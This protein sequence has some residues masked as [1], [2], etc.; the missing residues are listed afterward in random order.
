MT[1]DF[2]QRQ[3]QRPQFGH[4]PSETAIKVDHNTIRARMRV[5]SRGLL[6]TGMLSVVIAIAGLAGGIIY[7]A[8]NR[9]SI[10]RYWVVQLFGEE[11]ADINPRSTSARV[12]ELKEKR[13]AQ[14]QTAFALVL[15]AISIGCLIVA[16]VYMMYVSGGILM[17]QLKNYR[18]CR[19]V[20]LMAIVPVISPLIVVGIPFG[21]MGLA[22]LSK[23]EVKKAFDA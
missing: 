20:C 2:G 15:G 3:F 9:D 5:P 22:Q 12:K 11:I 16:S 21:L 6:L 19:W 18:F 1:S 10:K 13:E 7:S 4:D 8:M 14:A 17:G 23:P